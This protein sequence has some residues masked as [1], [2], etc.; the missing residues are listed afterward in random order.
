M[1][2]CCNNTWSHSSSFCK[3]IKMK[4]TAIVFAAGVASA[5]A[6]APSTP[7]ARSSTALNES[8]FSK[9]A[10]MDLWAPVKD[11]NDYGAR[12]RKKVNIDKIIEHS[13]VF[14]LYFNVCVKLSQLITSQTSFSIRNIALPR[15]DRNQLLRS[16]WTFC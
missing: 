11:S 7:V 13:N 5:A 1:N 14:L 9:I 15:K 12:N 16:C 3:I 10:N 4:V 6:F 2:F 8:I